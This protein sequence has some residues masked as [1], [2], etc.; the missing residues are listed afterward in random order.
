MS[1]ETEQIGIR[2]YIELRRKLLSDTITKKQVEILQL[3]GSLLELDNLENG[4]NK[5]E[6]KEEEQ[7]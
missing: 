2:T 3:Q 6:N 5:S 1:L 7:K 4:L